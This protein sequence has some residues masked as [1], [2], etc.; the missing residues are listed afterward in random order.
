MKYLIIIGRIARPPHE[1]LHESG[2]LVPDVDGADL[3]G[4]LEL[5]HEGGL[6]LPWLR[7]FPLTVRLRFQDV[8]RLVNLHKKVK[9]FKKSFF[10]KR[11]KIQVLQ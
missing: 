6:G 9:E 2:A 3:G 4:F 5:Q 1:Y 11:Y 8:L 7:A 10:F